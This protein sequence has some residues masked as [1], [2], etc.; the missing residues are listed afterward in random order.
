VKTRFSEN[1]SIN[2]LTQFIEIDSE[3]LEDSLINIEMIELTP[4]NKSQF[5]RMPAA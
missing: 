2:P 4:S 5:T 1:I 3:Q